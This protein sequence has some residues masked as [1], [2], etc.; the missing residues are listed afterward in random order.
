MY[1]GKYATQHPERPAF[2]MAGTGEAVSCREFEARSNRLARLLR[3]QGLKRL[4]HYAIFMDNNNRFLTPEELAC[5]IDNSESQL[6]IITSRAKLAVAA[7]AL[8]SCPKIKL[9]LVVD[10]GQ[11]LTRPC[12]DDAIAIAAYP[13]SAAHD[14]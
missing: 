6:L 9:C 10:G 12:K 14:E 1:P 7:E 5:I 2:I 8:K 3:A 13:G 4:E 11:G